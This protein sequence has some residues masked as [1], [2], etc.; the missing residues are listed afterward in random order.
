M[1][2]MLAWLLSLRP[3]LGTVR[4]DAVAGIPGAIASVPVGWRRLCSWA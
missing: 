3:E 4:Q 1:K 2:S